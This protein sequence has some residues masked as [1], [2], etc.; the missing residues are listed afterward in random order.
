MVLES[1]TEDRS[2]E[3]RSRI[4]R[5]IAVLSGKGGV[6]KSTFTANLALAFS[7][8]GYRVGVL[9]ADLHG[10]SIPKLLGMRGRR[11][12]GTFPVEGPAGVRVVSLDFLLPSDDTPLIW[13][14]PI[15]TVAIKQL[16]EEVEWGEL[17]LLLIDLPPGT[18]D[19]PLTVI[20]E[21]PEMDGVLL[22]TSPSELSTL[23]VGRAVGFSKKMGVKIL[24]VVEN[25]SGFTCPKCGETLRIFGEGGGRRMAEE[26]GIPFLGEI[27]L[28][29]KLSEDSDRGEPFI[30]KRPEAPA[31]KAFLELTRKLEQELD[32]KKI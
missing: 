12:E 23:V 21:L 30:L 19:E 9:D 20:Q 22:L 6:G 3:K 26:F 14:G 1:R 28:D 11:M 32:L 29:P 5:R 2:K 27:P 25:M 18:G 10:P 16:L 8:K 17:D 24:G 15:K 4:G 13:R 31:A 7:V